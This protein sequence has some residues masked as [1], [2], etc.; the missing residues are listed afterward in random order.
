MQD[1]ADGAEGL[2]YMLKRAKTAARDWLKEEAEDLAI[3]LALS[4]PAGGRDAIAQAVRRAGYAVNP[5]TIRRA[6]VR[7][8]LWW[9]RRC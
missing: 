8:R 4:I 6:V 7:R 1:V 5:S 9:E 2:V 3:R